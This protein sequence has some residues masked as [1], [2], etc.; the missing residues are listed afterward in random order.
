VGSLLL[1]SL[2]AGGGSPAGEEPEMPPQ[3]LIATATNNR[4]NPAAD[5][6]LFDRLMTESPA[7]FIQTF[8]LPFSN[9]DYKTTRP[10]SVGSIK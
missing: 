8:P 2:P 7:E 1:V 4:L 10:T 9:V 5:N 6:N 3:P